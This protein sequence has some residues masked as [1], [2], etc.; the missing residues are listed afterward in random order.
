M[1]KKTSNFQ[2]IRFQVRYF[3]D[4]EPTAKIRD[5]TRALRDPDVFQTMTETIE[6]MTVGQLREEVAVHFLQTFGNGCG[7]RAP[8]HL[9]INGVALDDQDL[10]IDHLADGDE[11]I[12]LDCIL[13][14][15]LHRRAATLVES[16]P[17]VHRH[18]SVFSPGAADHGE[19][20]AA[21]ERTV[22]FRDQQIQSSLSNVLKRASATQRELSFRNQQIESSKTL[23]KVLERGSAAQRARRGNPVN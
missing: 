18:P 21:G 5:S 3:L 13:I 6:T 20:D 1:K 7:L 22:S 19:T 17:A 16:P 12:V 10:V 2:F 4:K 15:I 11:E 9:E 8:H 23:S 14:P